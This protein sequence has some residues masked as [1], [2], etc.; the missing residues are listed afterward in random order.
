M[1]CVCHLL[2]HGG[3][4]VEVIQTAKSHSFYCKTGAMHLN[5]LD[6][7]PVR[8]VHCLLPSFKSLKCFEKI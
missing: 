8:Y 2:V 7:S 4:Q 3:I 6:E 1:R 5:C